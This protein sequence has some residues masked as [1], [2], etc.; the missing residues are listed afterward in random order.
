MENVR[1]VT[2][3][4]LKANTLVLRVTDRHGEQVIESFTLNG[5]AEALRSLPCTNLDCTGLLRTG[6]YIERK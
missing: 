3:D 2:R 1:E 6:G 5:L 4:A